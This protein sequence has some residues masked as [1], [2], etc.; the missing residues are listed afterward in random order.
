[1]LQLRV[2][3]ALLKSQLSDGISLEDVKQRVTTEE[4]AQHDTSDDEAHFK[5][6]YPSTSS[7]NSSKKNT[8]LLQNISSERFDE[9]CSEVSL[10]FVKI[11]F[12]SNNKYFLPILEQFGLQFW[13]LVN[14]IS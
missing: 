6:L 4:P 3:K 10:Q 9:N 11:E 13:K 8:L 2:E 14:C 7:E 1:M 12:C 5:A